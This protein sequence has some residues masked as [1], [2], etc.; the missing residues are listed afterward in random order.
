MSAHRSAPFL[1][2]R[3]RQEPLV[4]R[5]GATNALVH[6]NHSLKRSP[7]ARGE[8]R[9]GDGRGLP[10]PRPAAPRN[11]TG[12]MTALLRLSR[13]CICL[14]RTLRR[15]TCCGVCIRGCRD[16]EEVR[17]KQTSR[18]AS[19]RCSRV[20]VRP[21]AVCRGH[22]P[23]RISKVSSAHAQLPVF[24]E[25]IAGG[26]AS[27]RPLS[28]ARLSDAVVTRTAGPLRKPSMADAGI[29]AFTAAGST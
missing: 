21:Q 26:I 11:A 29:P 6:K 2:Q 19:R 13:R 16:M 5:R 3:N 18:R 27:T 10:C 28:A 12:C 4:G 14:G 17:L 7:Q 20:R 25:Q 9:R 8:L 1:P 24:G 15:S 23:I 22:H